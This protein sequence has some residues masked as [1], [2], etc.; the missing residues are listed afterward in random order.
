[1]K[2]KL[3]SLFFI[4]LIASSLYAKDTSG[5]S[6]NINI[7]EEGVFINDVKLGGT[8]KIDE[9]DPILGKYDVK[10]TR[11]DGLYYTWDKLGIKL[12]EDLTSQTIN[13]LSIYLVISRTSDTKNPFVGK[14][15]VLSKEVNAKVSPSKFSNDIIC[16]QIFCTFKTDNISVNTNL[17]EDKKKFKILLVKID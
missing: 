9:Y 16:Q 15:N 13:Q 10:E 2:Q 11:E 8:F 3:A 17:T 6:L 1:M 12:R 14:V 4:F 7:K 5:K